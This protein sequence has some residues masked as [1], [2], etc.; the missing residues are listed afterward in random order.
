MPGWLIGISLS[1]NIELKHL[2]F[3]IICMLMMIM[4]IILHKMLINHTD[5]KIARRKECA[6]ITRSINNM[7]AKVHSVL[8]KVKKNEE[9]K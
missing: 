6:Q 7:C 2:T 3:L 1:G 8:K 9:Q 4:R 5:M